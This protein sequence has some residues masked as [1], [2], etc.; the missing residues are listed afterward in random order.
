VRF[1]LRTAS[2][3]SRPVNVTADE[4]SRVRHSKWSACSVD[5]RLLAP[6]SAGVASTARAPVSNAPTAC[7]RKK[8]CGAAPV[9]TKTIRSMSLRSSVPPSVLDQGGDLRSYDSL[10]QTRPPK[11]GKVSSDLE[12]TSADGHNHSEF[13][14]ENCYRC[15]PIQGSNPC[16]SAKF[17]FEWIEIAASYSQCFR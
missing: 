7:A 14:L 3:R 17:V 6:A 4:M 13:G 16:P 11:R 5:E 9:A 1:K 8:P 10:D 12:Q 2:G 15:K